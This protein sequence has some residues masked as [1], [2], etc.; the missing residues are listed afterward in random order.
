M[1]IELSHRSLSP[2]TL[3]ALIQIS[4]SREAQ[5]AA[6]SALIELRL[7][8]T[9]MRASSLLRYAAGEPGGQAWLASLGEDLRKLRQILAHE[10]DHAKEMLKAD[11]VV[12]HRLDGAAGA[13]ISEAA[14]VQSRHLSAAASA[15]REVS[16]VKNEL[17]L[18][19]LSAAEVDAVIAARRGQTP[20]VV[21]HEHA[22][23]SATLKCQAL[24]AFLQDPLRST[25]CLDATLLGELED[26][27]ASMTAQAADA[28][29]RS[30]S[31]A[32]RQ[33][34]PAVAVPA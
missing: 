16:A 17:A 18:A 7:L 27:V 22:A 19:G 12:R 30:R 32:N 1:K 21:A 28:I 20:E 29:E 26:K 31:W 24:S 9:S 33:V 34:A 14:D 8:A 23:Q 5:I 10:T 3:P 15:R 13:L 6:E 2:E 4:Q 11:A 25:S